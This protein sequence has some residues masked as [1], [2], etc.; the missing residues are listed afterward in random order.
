[1]VGV[2]VLVGV[3]VLVGVCV[4]VGVLVGPVDVLR[5]YCH[6]LLPPVPVKHVYGEVRVMTKE[7]I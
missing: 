4:K 7:Q 6:T 3:L 1:L 5:V 2:R